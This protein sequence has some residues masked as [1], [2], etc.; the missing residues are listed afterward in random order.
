M[1]GRGSYI[2][3]WI[4][5]CSMLC[6]KKKGNCSWTKDEVILLPFRGEATCGLTTSCNRS[7]ALRFF[8]TAFEIGHL[9]V[10]LC[11]LPHTLAFPSYLSLRP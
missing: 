6:K 1:N 8:S 7:D 2:V 5:H 9:N 10:H 3:M 4:L 11:S